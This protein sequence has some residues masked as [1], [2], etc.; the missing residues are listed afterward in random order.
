M[1]RAC[2]NPRMRTATLGSLSQQRFLRRPGRQQGEQHARRQREHGTMLFP[3]DEMLAVERCDEKGLSMSR[4]PDDAHSRIFRGKTRLDL[5]PRGGTRGLPFLGIEVAIVIVVESREQPRLV[6][7]PPDDDLAHLALDRFDDRA[8]AQLTEYR[9][10]RSLGDQPLRIAIVAVRTPRPPFQ[11]WQTGG[12][13]HIAVP[14]LVRSRGHIGAHWPN[15]TLTVGIAQGKRRDT[16]GAIDDIPFVA[17][18]NR[19][20]MLDLVVPPH[21]R[22]PAQ[23]CGNGSFGRGSG[24]PFHVHVPLRSGTDPRD[25]RICGKAIAA[26]AGEEAIDGVGRASGQQ[27]CECEEVWRQRLRLHLLNASLT[28]T[29]AVCWESNF[30]SRAGE[31]WNTPAMNA[32]GNVSIRMFCAFAASL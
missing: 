27:D 10:V 2:L 29:S 8:G 5:L 13:G 11:P 1:M 3:A 22:Q 26:Q 25:G 19:G 9:Q 21:A 7:L 6:L 18:A 28:S 16:G 31:K 15:E 17:V 4:L 23:G 24:P 20:A 32:S 30:R 12:P 14:G